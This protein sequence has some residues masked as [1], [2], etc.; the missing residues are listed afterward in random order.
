MGRIS[1]A[2][3]WPA[4]LS[5]LFLLK[6]LDQPR[7]SS[8]MLLVLSVW[9]TLAVDQQIALYAFVWMVVLA[10]MLLPF[11][12][13]RIANRRFAA[14]AALVMVLVAPAAYWLFVQPFVGQ[15]G[16]TVP[17]AAEASTYSYPTSLLWTPAMIWR[18]YGTVIPVGLLAA[19]IVGVNTPSVFPWLAGAALCIWLSLGPRD[20]DG[21]LVSAFSVLTQL[22]G[23]A[24]FR[25]PYRFQIPAVIGGAMYLAFVVAW[26]GTRTR[27]RG[28]PMVAVA[29]VAV[30]DMTAYRCLY[31]F[32]LQTRS[33]HPVY[34]TLADAQDQDARPVLEV[35][36]GVRTAPISSERARRSASISPS[37]GGV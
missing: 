16:Y 6:L 2:G 26:L 36:V 33:H 25:T 23:L 29:V 1:C 20:A 21:P 11:R 14:A 5:L 9:A 17:A 12:M 28:V 27:R 13:S 24:Q 19:L 18:V 31:G 32:P 8:A 3:V 10:C 7:V 15:A 4:I 30:A 34:A 37:I 35:P 22:P